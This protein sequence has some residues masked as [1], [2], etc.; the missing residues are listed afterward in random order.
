MS[1]TIFHLSDSVPLTKVG[2]KAYNLNRLYRFGFNVPEAWFLPVEAMEFFLRENNILPLLYAL[3]Q[4][5]KVSRG[6]ALEAARALRAEIL[7]AP[8]PHELLELIKESVLKEP[9]GRFSVRS[10]SI[11]EDLEQ[12]SYAGQYASVLDVAPVVADLERSIR[13][14]WAS[15][16]S[17]PLINYAFKNSYPIPEP[18]MGVVIQRMVEP[19][20]AGVLFSYNPFTFN[21]NEMVLEYVKGLGEGLV[22]GE[23]TPEH[24]IYSRATSAFK[25]AGDIPKKY[26]K[27]FDMLIQGAGT[28]EKKT[29]L[30]VDIEWAYDGEALYYLQM[31]AITT[32][33]QNHI[34]WTD[35]NVGE[36][37]PDIVTPYSWSI[38]NPI[39]NGAFKKFLQELGTDDY[40]EHGLFGLYKGK[41]YL[42][43][44]AF[45][46]TMSRFYLSSYKPAADSSLALP[47]QWLRLLLFPLRI[48]RALWRVWRLSQNMEERMKRHIVA[49]GQRL[50][51][52]SF[53]KKEDARTAYKRID[54]LVELHHETM[55]LHVTNTILAEFYFQLLKKIIDGWGHA[56]P[57]AGAEA[58]LAGLGEAESARS[59]RALWKISQKIKSYPRLRSLFD[60]DDLG[61]LEKQLLETDKEK[62]IIREIRAFLREFGHGALHEFELLYP[63]WQ[64]D[65][66]YIYANI[67]NYLNSEIEDLPE[68]DQKLSGMR[69]DMLRQLRENM[70]IFKRPVFNYIY[71]RAALFSSQRENLKQCLLKAHFELKK[72]LLHIGSVL[73]EKKVLDRPGDILFLQHEEIKPYLAEKLPVKKVTTLIAERRKK[74]ASDINQEHPPRMMQIGELWRPVIEES[75]DGDALQGIGCSAGVVEGRARIIVNEQSFNRL[76]KGDILVAASTNPGWTPLFMTAAG[77]VTEIGGALS[78]GAIIAREYGIPMV[79]AVKKATKLIA[80]GDRIRV[81]GSNGQVEILS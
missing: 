23:K 70:N 72:H 50:K 48:G 38:L 74:R 19:E 32:M 7:K 54:H 49:H 14:V 13:R 35:E 26:I 65:R 36:V 51:A 10:S 64:E 44:T 20:I 33:G 66:S 40:P 62:V 71:S 4:E 61:E 17:E 67:Q 78:H 5:G 2:A 47:V 18:G 8:L 27:P 16:W 25:Q 79:T 77:V 3:R 37:I 57:G 55:H 22:S 42:N 30:A 52:I 24:L 81:N 80:D 43:H 34:L 12:N 76:Q 41:V 58:V 75:S 39:T 59:G 9:R 29:G 53:E 11:N 69:S 21:K 73:V 45:N 28:L 56:V 68:H 31:R 60:T 15:Q 63:R 6:N 46:E 1:L